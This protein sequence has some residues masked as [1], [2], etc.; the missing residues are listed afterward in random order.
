MNGEC[1]T[2]ANWLDRLACLFV[3]VSVGYARIQQNIDTL[4]IKKIRRRFVNNLHTLKTAGELLG[5]QQRGE[6]K[7]YEKKNRPI[8]WLAK[9]NNKLRKYGM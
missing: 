9:R 6:T 4:L 5:L 3:Y 2:N 8:S 7:I 1:W